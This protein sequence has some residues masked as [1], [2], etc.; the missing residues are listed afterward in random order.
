MRR[1]LK[2]IEK[3]L[4]TDALTGLANRTAYKEELKRIIDKKNVGCIVLDINNL[5]LCND[6]YG[7]REGDQLISDA[8]ECVI[9]AFEPI[10]KCFRIGGDEFNIIFDNINNKDITDAINKFNELIKEKNENRTFPLSIA[11]GHSTRENLEDLENMINR[12]DKW[13]YEIKDRM[14]NKNNDID[15][16]TKYYRNV[17]E[18]I[19]RS[20]DDFLFLLDIEKDENWFF[21]PVD[22]DYNL[23]DKGKPTN[24]IEDMLNIVHPLDREMVKNDMELILKGEKNI[25]DMNYRWINKDG[26]I[27]WIN[28]RGIVIGD[29]EGKP[30]IMIGRVSEE[31]LRH[32]YNSLTGLWNKRKM[33]ED[34]KVK[35]NNDPNGYLMLL[36]IDDFAALNLSYGREYGNDLLKKLAHN[37]ENIDK[38]TNIYHTDNNYFVLFVDAKNNKEIREVYNNIQNKM[39]DIC[40]FT[41][42]VTPIN[43]KY[44]VDDNS[45]Y[46]SAKYLLNSAKT[47]NKSIEYFSMESIEEKI[48]SVELYHELNESV[49]NNFK[50]FEIYYQPQVKAGNY[51]LFSIEALLRY[52][53]PTLGKITPNI[54]IPVLEHTRLINNVGLWV[55]EQALLQC[56]EW[57][58]NIPDLKV[59]VNF[60]TVQFEDSNIAD[61]IIDILK[62]TD[63]PGSALTIEFT[64]SIKIHESEL[65]NKN[66][67][68]L[69]MYGVSLSIDDFGTGYSNLAYLKQ[70]DINEIKID[71]SFVNSIEENT[72]NYKLISNI[73][74]FAK[75]NNIRV[76]C[77]GVESTRELA[78]LE[79][80]SPNLIQGFLFD[81]PEPTHYIE[82]TYMN[83]DSKEFNDRI[84]FIEKIYDFKEKMGFVRFEP[85]DILRET[86]VGLWIIRLNP[87][88]GSY[89]M[90]A[91]ETMEKNMAV[92]KK[93]TPKECYEH[94]YDRIKPTH[95]DYVLEKIEDMKTSNGVVE[96]EYPWIHPELGEIVVRSSGRR[97]E[98]ND[99]MII[100]EGYH[101]LVNNR[102]LQSKTLS[103]TFKESN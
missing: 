36:D 6:K 5:K 84:K 27:V 15:D 20:T 21:G 63:M 37:L 33:R 92:D 102:N 50:G 82:K 41:A 81:K 12:A 55:L 99:G 14:K 10:G 31:A 56:K 18:L 23:R 51:N 78:M 86:G 73:I 72:Y 7:H 67:D 38:I 75:T 64:E 40:T 34:L 25:H 29:D 24:T 103:K 16:K 8:S 39:K 61:K 28:C 58:K 80:L 65:I 90:H 66:M 2:D 43:K 91:D 17:I 69:K 54:F 71:R 3:L 47:N 96:M 85:K 79:S 94:W 48:V 30:F 87:K 1:E 26:N 62:K 95:L 9:K 83:K 35:F 76:C 13:M 42:S 89:E 100:L 11:I 22:K 101:K 59:S 77:E 74:E 44:F 68:L 98:D 4:Y 60:S 93:Y 49:K 70:L 32:L 45:L 97:V 52:T 57:R 88:D 46:D 19:S 53:S